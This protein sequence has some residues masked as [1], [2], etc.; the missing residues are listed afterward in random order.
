MGQDFFA[1]PVRGLHF[2]LPL[3]RAQDGYAL[4]LYNVICRN[5]VVGTRLPFDRLSTPSALPYWLHSYVNGTTTS[6][7]GVAKDG[8]IRRFLPTEAA[9][10]SLTAGITESVGFNFNGL[11]VWTNYPT[12]APRTYD[13]AAI[14]TPAFTLPATGDWATLTTSDITGGCPFKGRVF[15]W[16]FKSDEFLYT[17]LNAT[18]GTVSAFALKNIAQTGGNIKMITTLTMDG[19]V[20]Q[21]DLLCFILDTGEMIVYA[22]DD[23]SSIASF[24]KV[25]AFKIPPPLAADGVTRMGGDTLIG[26]ANGLIPVQNFITQGFGAIEADWLKALN[27]ELQSWYSYLETA[28]IRPCHIAN[29]G[30][31]VVIVEQ[32]PATTD[33]STMFVMDTTSRAWSRFV[34]YEDG[35]GVAFAA[36]S[37]GG[38]GVAA[39]HGLQYNTSHHFHAIVEHSGQL[40]ASAYKPDDTANNVVKYNLNSAAANLS[41]FGATEQPIRM[42]MGLPFQAQVEETVIVGNMLQ[43]AVATSQLITSHTLHHMFNGAYPTVNQFTDATDYTQGLSGNLEVLNTKKQLGGG[44]GWSY[45]PV[46]IVDYFCNRGTGW[47]QGIRFEGLRVWHNPMQMHGNGFEAPA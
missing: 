25:G 10:A 40:Y 33:Y 21:D 45:A 2:G 30:L 26:T 6:L 43:F 35:G 4:E 34:I 27:P 31:L 29:R 13:G 41:D 12:N 28:R 44:S 11:L 3:Q 19:G 16:S 24:Q 22:G 20:G 7:I 47:D 32:G 9:V 17:A 38:V 37:R 5:G 46:V 15:Y 42:L 1:P 14:A 23:P 8:T 18:A 39:N 36:F